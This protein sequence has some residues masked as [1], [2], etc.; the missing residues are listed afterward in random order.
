MFV[1]RNR[2]YVIQE[3]IADSLKINSC[4][5]FW[6]EINK[7]KP[8]SKTLTNI[9]DGRIGC[10]EIVSHLKDKYNDLYNLFV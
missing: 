9:M 5:L 4:K 8:K 2:E 3:E 1:K 10:G 7:L 6:S